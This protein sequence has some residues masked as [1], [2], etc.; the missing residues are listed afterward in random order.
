MAAKKEEALVLVSREQLLGA[1]KRRF[2]ILDVPN[3]GKVR[4]RSLTE[5]E[6]TQFESDNLDDKCL[7]DK[8]Q[9]LLAKR[10]LIVLCVVDA[11]GNP[12]LTLEDA[13]RLADIDGAITGFLA[14]A[15]R[16]FCGF[17]KQD[18]EKIKGN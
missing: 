17:E 4:V 8:E 16:T 5:R 10:R 13:E 12:T 1:T 15:L 11:E 2:T 6:R 14:D 7:V 9:A 18:F 3:L